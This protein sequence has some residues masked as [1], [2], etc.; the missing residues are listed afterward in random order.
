MQRLITSIHNNNNLPWVLICGWAICVKLVEEW[1]E[2]YLSF[3]IWR[4]VLWNVLFGAWYS[5]CTDQLKEAMC[6][7]TYTKQASQDSNMNEE[8]SPMAPALAEEQLSTDGCERRRLIYLRTCG[9]WQVVH[10]P[11]GVF[12][13]INRYSVLIGLSGFINIFRRY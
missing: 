10:I 12:T 7:M 2:K 1:S 5:R 13:H 9:C 11:V 6:P 4:E 3:S 8:R